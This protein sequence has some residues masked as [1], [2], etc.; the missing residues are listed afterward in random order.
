MSTDFVSELRAY[1]ELDCNNN[2][3][4]LDP[5]ELWL[6]YDH[7]LGRKESD[8]MIGVDCHPTSQQIAF[9]MEETAEYSER[10]LNHSVGEAQLCHRHLHQRGIRTRLRRSRRFDLR[11]DDFGPMATIQMCLVVLD[12][13]HD[14]ARS[15]LKSSRPSKSRGVCVHVLRGLDV[16]RNL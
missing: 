10:E 16:G 3:D 15:R 14:F 13:I 6:L 5:I 1:N 8:M 11:Q 12:R 9:L 7:W 2:A 4:S